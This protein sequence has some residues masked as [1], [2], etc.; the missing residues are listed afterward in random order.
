MDFFDVVWPILMLW[1]VWKA[2]YFENQFLVQCFLVTLLCYIFCYRI[3]RAIHKKLWEI[4]LLYEAREAEEREAAEEY[5]GVR[6]SSNT[7]SRCFLDTIII[8]AGSLFMNAMADLSS[9]LNPAPTSGPATEDTYVKENDVEQRRT[10]APNLP[11]IQ[12]GA[13]NGQPS[14]KS[15]L[16]TL[17]DA[18]TSSVPIL[19]PTH[20][21]STAFMNLATY[22]PPAVQSTS[23]PTSSR[24]S[25]PQSYDPSNVPAPTSPSFTPGLQQYHHPTSNE[26]RA[27]RPSETAETQA[28]SL[29]PLRSDLPDNALSEPQ[30]SNAQLHLEDPEPSILPGIEAA[31]ALGSDVAPSDPTKDEPAISHEPSLNAQSL[32]SPSTQLNQREVKSEINDIAP[33][34]S[35]G[36]T[37]IPPQ[38]IEL[39]AETDLKAEPDKLMKPTSSPAADG[40]KGQN[41]SPKPQPASNRKRPAPKKGTATTVKPAAKKR[42]VDTLESV[43]NASPLAHS[44]TPASSRASK[45]PAPRG[46]KQESATPQRSSSIANDDDEDEDGVFCICRGPDNHTW[47]IAC[48]GPCEDWFHGRCIDMSEK[49]GE[50]IEKYYCMTPFPRAPGWT[51]LN[52][53]P[54]PNCTEEGHG[55]TLWKR[56]CRLDDCRR[57][58]RTNGPKKS[59]YCSD[60]H[61]CEFMRRQALKKGE[62]EDKKKMGE[63]TPLTT[64][65]KKGGRKTNNSFMDSGLSDSTNTQNQMPDSSLQPPMKDDGQDNTSGKTSRHCGGILQPAELKALTNGVNNISD[66]HKLGNGMP[67]PPPPTASKHPKESGDVKTEDPPPAEP[68]NINQIP[69]TPTET[70]HLEILNA[71]KDELRSRKKLLD[72][73]DT[74]LTLVRERAKGILDELKKKENIKDICGFDTRLI[75]SDEEFDIWRKSPEGMRDLQERKLSAPTQLDIPKDLSSHFFSSGDNMT[76]GIDEEQQQHPAASTNGD[77]VSTVPNDGEQSAED[78]FGKGVCQKKRCE[79]HK[80][81]YKLQQQEIA[82]AKDEV[83]QGMRKLDEE[84]KGVRD[85]AKIRWLGAEVDEGVA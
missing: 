61:G 2:P 71:K 36:S 44:G 15:P 14:I 69:Y 39:T 45:T 80:A 10:K 16:D 5:E 17:A 58:A 75:W 78:E 30:Q 68:L 56:M 1:F 24:I 37:Q 81:W 3:Y 84:E 19:S 55:E 43:E 12:I 7:C 62:E 28:A 76:N 74:F 77:T 38:A 54:G 73:R 83:R 33:T 11:P 65:S 79:R 34:L 35:P 42:K 72:E 6:L 31:A 18:A 40:D 67:I 13:P 64:A 8:A 85:R 52:D 63:N 66:F 59:K 41:A 51:L 48:D 23:R 57:P 20:S 70:S 49:D 60:E 4:K 46:R 27:R 53:C 47:M 25:P 22:R 82:F 21:N 50:L 26:V 9:L 32:Q 29:P